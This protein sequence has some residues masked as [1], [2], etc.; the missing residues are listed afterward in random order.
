MGMSQLGE[1]AAAQ[2]GAYGTQTSHDIGQNMI[3]G[4]NARAA[5]MIGSGNAWQGGLNGI[6]NMLHRRRGAWL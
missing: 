6:S 1:N 2:T 5:G 4:G 3:G